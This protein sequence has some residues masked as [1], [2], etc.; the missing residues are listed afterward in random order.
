MNSADNKHTVGIIGVRDLR[1]RV[2]DNGPY[3][4]SIIRRHITLIGLSMRDI[5]VCT[6]GSKGVEKLII[7]WCVENKIPYS[8]ITP[9]IKSLGSERAF[10]VRNIEV[11]SSSDSLV[12]YW[13][14]L[15]PAI[16]KAIAQAMHVGKAVTTYPVL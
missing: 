12:F 8:C 4:V 15:V 13:D 16:P 6:G 14:G 3:A 7:D 9:K 1:G 11:V 10:E 5:R 2:Y